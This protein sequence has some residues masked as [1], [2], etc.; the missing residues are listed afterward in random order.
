MSCGTIQS[1]A[2]FFILA[3]FVECV[4]ICKINLVFARWLVAYIV[5][6]AIE[7]YLNT[8]TYIVAYGVMGSGKVDCTATEWCFVGDIR[9]SADSVSTVGRDYSG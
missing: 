9:I 7:S 4:Y 1:S 3:V 6:A 5:V 8:R 2:I